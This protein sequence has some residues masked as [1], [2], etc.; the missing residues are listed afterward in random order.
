MYTVTVR[1]RN[2]GEDEFRAKSVSFS[3]Q[4]LEQGGDQLK[5]FTYTTPSGDQQSVFLT[6][7]LVAG[8]VIAEE[9]D[10]LEGFGL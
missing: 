9:R 5:E 6:P 10:V 1:Y 3:A 7:N 8:I 2:G 4:D